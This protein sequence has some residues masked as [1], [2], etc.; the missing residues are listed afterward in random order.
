MKTIKTTLIAILALASTSLFAQSVKLPALSPTQSVEQEFSLS[1]INLTY[2]RPSARGRKVFGDVVP[3]GKIWRTGANKSTYIKFGE[4]VTIDGQALK[5]GEYSIA[6][7]PGETEW[8]I[9]FNSNTN[10]WGAMGYKQEEDVLRV[11]T[12]VNKTVNF[13][14][15][16]TIEFQ[17]I[18]TKSADLEMKWEN[19]S[20]TLKIQ[21]AVN[22]DALI[23]TSIE[24]GLKDKRPYFQAANYYYQSKRD[25]NQALT[26]VNEAIKM[27]TN[28]FYMDHLKAKIQV[29]LK[30]LKGALKTAEIS[31]NKAIRAKNDDYIKNND[32]LI[33][34][35]KKKM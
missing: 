13:I 25:M 9:I 21:S 31:K 3:F 22:Q 17:N 7:I 20:V 18:T 28:A 14:E 16:F 27:D 15:T 34:D 11:K 12:K 6:T 33:A 1:K 23:M 35:I 32:N 29:E 4:D 19:T 8:T 5:A 10:L 30:D 24:E 2:S 26:W